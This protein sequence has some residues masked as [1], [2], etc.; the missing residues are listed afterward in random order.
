LAARPDCKQVRLR[1]FLV[2]EEKEGNCMNPPE[3]ISSKKYLSLPLLLLV[4]LSCYADPLS[5]LYK[6]TDGVSGVRSKYD[7]WV[8]KPGE[9]RCIENIAGPGK[10]TFFY[11]TDNSGGQIYDGLVLKVHWDDQN[12]AGINVP[13]GAF[14]GVFNKKTCDYQS[15]PMQ[16]NHLCYM[17]CLPM[18]FSKAAKFYIA[19][20]G[21]ETY[22]RLIA[23]GIDF[24]LDEQLKTEKSRLYCQWIRSNPTL[25]GEHPILNVQG[26]GHYIG[27]FL[28][29]YST[30]SGWWGEGDTIFTIDGKM[31]IHTPGTEDEYGSCW[32]FGPLFS[33]P[34]A[35]Y[36]QNESGH[37][38]MYRWYLDNPV[39]FQK[40]LKVII[41]NRRFQ[42]NDFKKGQL[43]SG[44]DY[45]SV[46]FWYQE[47]GNVPVPLDTYEKRTAA[48]N[49][50][51]Y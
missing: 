30:Y 37:Y 18:P 51:K 28:Q 42:G 34:Y 23:Y 20:D 35:G 45:T 7:R 26:K 11:F 17:S 21:N 13:L 50:C 46:A 40:S 33:L 29:I 41:Q 36:I 12:F 15:L 14:W 16:V 27:N 24:E 32:G 44:D 10:I 2:S 31:M 48:S 19:N 43:E 47:D 4:T 9:Q 38:R 3:I 22:D 1:G 25:H 6:I 5:N 8:I 39:R 49:A